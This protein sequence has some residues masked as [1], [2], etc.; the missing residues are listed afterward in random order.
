MCLSL[1]E[2]EESNAKGPGHTSTFQWRSQ[3]PCFQTYPRIFIICPNL[4][5]WTII[6]RGWSLSFIY[7]ETVAVTVAKIYTGL[8]GIY[9]VP[10]ITLSIFSTSHLYTYG[11]YSAIKKNGMLTFATTWMKLER[12]NAKWNKSKENKKKK[13]ILN[14]F[15]HMLYI[16]K[17]E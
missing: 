1:R 4:R 11:Y 5:Q 6:S 13:Q 16:K 15:T 7:R 12:N 2:E 14:D 9:F 3:W 17:N 8:Y 10:G